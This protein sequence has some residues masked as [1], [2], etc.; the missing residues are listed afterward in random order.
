MRGEM[1]ALPGVN[2]LMEQIDRPDP[3]TVH[4][5]REG[6]KAVLGARLAAPLR[7]QYDRASACPA[8]APGARG[9]RKVK[10]QALAWRAASDPQGVAVLAT[11]QY[12]E[13]GRAHV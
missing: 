6:L 1:L 3:G 13:I 8:D 11:R 5:E 7:A 9:A 4:L 10:T 2:F 12:R